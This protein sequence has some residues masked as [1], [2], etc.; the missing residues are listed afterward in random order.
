MKADQIM[1]A[2]AKH[3][4]RQAMLNVRPYIYNA[5]CT[6]AYWNEGNLKNTFAIGPCLPLS[7]D[8]GGHAWT[9][10]VSKR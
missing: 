3:D 2:I 7:G 9:V 4:E 10:S 1:L 6:I 5:L 8:G